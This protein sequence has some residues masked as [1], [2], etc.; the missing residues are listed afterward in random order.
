MSDFLIILLGFRR[1][2]RKLLYISSLLFIFFIK[3]TTAQTAKAFEE[4]GD[5]A[6]SRKDYNAALQYFL[7]ASAAKSSDALT[8]KMAETARLY[9]SYSL[10]EKNYQKLVTANLVKKYPTSRFYAALMQKYQGKYEEAKALFEET[11]KD[12]NTE[13]DFVAQARK[14]IKSCEWAAGIIKTPKDITVE[15]LG[16]AINTP[17]SDFAAVKEDGTIYY[18]SL[19]FENKDDQSNPPRLLT[20]VLATKD[21]TVTAKALSKFNTEGKHTAYTAFSKKTKKVFFTNCDYTPNGDE[22]LCNIYVRE[23]DGENWGKAEIL[24]DF[25]N[26]PGASNTMPFVAEENGQEILYFVSNR[27][28]GKGKND[29]WYSTILPNGGYAYPINLAAVNTRGDEMSPY[30]HAANKTLY[31]SSDGYESLGGLDIFSSIKNRS[32]F[33]TPKNMGAPLNSSYNDLYFNLLEDGTEGYLASNRLGSLYLDK[34]NET[35]CYDVYKAKIGKKA[36]EEPKK[37]TPKPPVESV[38]NPPKTTTNVPPTPTKTNT[39]PTNTPINTPPTTVSKDKPKGN[40]PSN[41]PP[42]T[43][44]TPPTKSNKTPPPGYQPAPPG[45]K[46]NIPKDIPKEYTT[47]EDFLPLPLY[48]DND[49]PD[50]NTRAISTNKTYHTA[51]DAYYKRKYEYIEKNLPK[52]DRPAAISSMDELF[53]K[54]IRQNFVKLKEFTPI[55]LGRLYKG[56]KIEIIVKGF[57]SPLAK[58]DYNTSLGKRRVAS[59]VNFW[60]TYEGGLFQKYF[61]NGQLKITQVSFGEDT[62]AQNISDDEHNEAASIYSVGAAKERRIEIIEVKKN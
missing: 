18:S 56:E 35:C 33:S 48:F 26:F 53:E 32:N 12:P 28:D 50:R 4:A 29:I 10:A 55:L 59:L 61:D 23:K 27:K 46:Y 19:R 2:L 37:E 31:F 1:T 6:S 30:Y 34:K 36:L 7:E 13:Y 16:N 54:T 52:M 5:A 41:V 39:P 38:P 14:E 47:L 40:I 42:T 60:K 44:E 20:K 43:V 51:F 21:T 58:N 22:I 9:N 45:T 24:P 62:A 57:A 8:F 11:I 49:E 15:H 17:Y 25:I 3:N